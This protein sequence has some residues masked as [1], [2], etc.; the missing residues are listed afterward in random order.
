MTKVLSPF[1]TIYR[2]QITSM[3]SIMERVTGIILMLLVFMYILL[4]KYK[5]VLLI[6]YSYYTILYVLV[7]G[8]TFLF[9]INTGIIFIIFNFYYHLIFGGRYLYWDYTGGKANSKKDVLEISL[10]DIYK[11]GYILIGICCI[12]TVI[13]W[14]YLIT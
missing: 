3:F 7:K 2:P 1:L 13:S 6:N 14:I 11:S 9:F 12:L 8:S 5:S 10:K 4:M